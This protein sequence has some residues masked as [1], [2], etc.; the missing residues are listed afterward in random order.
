MSL[1][2]APTSL[3]ELLNM[4]YNKSQSWD[5]YSSVSIVMIYLCRYHHIQQNVI[6]SRMTPHFIQQE[7]LSF[8][9]TA[10]DHE[11]R[12]QKHLL[13]R[14]HKTSHRIRVSSVGWLWR[15]TL[16]KLNSLHR[17]AGK[18]I[19]PDLSLSTEQKMNAFGIL[20]LPQQLTYNKG[21][22]MYK[23]LNNT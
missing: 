23:V 1:S 11:H 8:F 9:S 15:S 7:K 6:C 3:K 18:L 10:T 5:L 12:H 13:Q 14:S 21:V 19:L 16:K 20:N 2:V 22:F 4:V 17:R